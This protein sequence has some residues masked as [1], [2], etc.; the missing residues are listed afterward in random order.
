MNAAVA[1][2]LKTL[3][4]ASQTPLEGVFSGSSLQC[5]R[6]SS[7]GR[8]SASVCLTA[9]AACVQVRQMS[10]EEAWRGCIE[11]RKRKDHF[12][13][14]VESTGVLRPEQ[15]CSRA[16]DILAAKCDKLLEHL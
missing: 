4:R 15:L 16:L 3:T 8:R 14:T 5:K 11:L 6:T 9:H 10:G 13:Y 1:V 12:I 2:K 7:R